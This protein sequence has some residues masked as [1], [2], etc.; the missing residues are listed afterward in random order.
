MRTRVSLALA[1]GLACALAACATGPKFSGF[2]QTPPGKGDI[3][4]YREA[5][6]FAS[7]QDFEIAVDGMKVGDLSNGGYLKIQVGPGAHLVRASIN[8]G[9]GMASKDARVWTEDGKRSFVLVTVGLKGANT[10]SFSVG[11]TAESDAVKILPNLSAS[12]AARDR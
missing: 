9:F 2:E 7:V 5:K 11:Q 8:A 4:V 3:Y 6:L 1:I 12:T 10:W